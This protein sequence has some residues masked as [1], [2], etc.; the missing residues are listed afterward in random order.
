M[1]PPAMPGRDAVRLVDAHVTRW[2]GTDSTSRMP[3]VEGLRGA[4]ELGEGAVGIEEVVDAV[5]LGA[6][7]VL[8]PELQ[9]GVAGETPGT[10]TESGRVAWLAFV[11][12]VVEDEHDSSES[13]VHERRFMLSEPTIEP[14]VVDD[15]D[16]GVHVDGGAL[17]VLEV[18]DEH[19]VAAG[20]RR[21]VSSGPFAPDAA[22]GP[23]T[24]PS[25]SGKRGTTTTTC[26]SGCARNASASARAARSDQKYWS[27]RYTSRRARRQGLQVGA[28]DA[29]LAL[30]C[31]GVRRTLRRIRAQDLHRVGTTRR[32]LAGAEA[33]ADRGG[34]V[35][36]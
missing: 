15:A 30:G 5:G 13:W 4:A 8:A 10:V 9:P 23:A 14:D 35:G 3:C 1:R 34:G 29:A 12:G 26:S 11:A 16:L 17:L 25:R 24:R 18:A 2:S 20:A 7:E 27:S 36:G 31:E 33:A 32:R 6:T 21:R 19:P 28:G 22:A